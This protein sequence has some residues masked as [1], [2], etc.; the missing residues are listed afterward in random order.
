MIGLS[1]EISIK[2]ETIIENEAFISLYGSFISNFSAYAMQKGL[3]LLKG[4][5]GDKIASDCF[6]LSEIPM[7]EKAVNK[8]PFDA[9]GVLTYDKDIISEGV[10]KTALYN[11]KSAYK[12]TWSSAVKLRLRTQI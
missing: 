1:G 9:E 12:V 5:V 8:V 3:S 4:R 11:L 7:Y 2:Y 6:T 10:F